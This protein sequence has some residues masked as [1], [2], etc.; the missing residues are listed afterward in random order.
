VVEQAVLWSA[1][2]IWKKEVAW[3][4]EAGQASHNITLTHIQLNA[5]HK[6]ISSSD[7]V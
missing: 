7:C 1:S 4:G 5:S 2:N 6:C 3:E